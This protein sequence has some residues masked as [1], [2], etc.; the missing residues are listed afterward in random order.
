[1]IYSQILHNVMSGVEAI[2]NRESDCTID[3]RRSLMRQNVANIRKRKA[4]D[5]IFERRC[6]TQREVSTVALQV[7]IDANVTQILEF[8]YQPKSIDCTLEE[9]H[10][11]RH[12]STI[13]TNRD[14]HFL[15][16]T[17][18]LSLFFSLS[19]NLNYLSR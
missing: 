3:C 18:T 17:C 8:I 5:D 13:M 12:D 19:S 9:L 10:S 16:H 6:V 15:Q 1:M 4:T 14:K 2:E 11:A 7:L